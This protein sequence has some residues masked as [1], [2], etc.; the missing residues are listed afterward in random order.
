MTERHLQ[1]EA[2][3]RCPQC[4]GTPYRL[5]RRSTEANPEIFTHLVWPT[6]PGVSP[7]ASATLRCPADGCELA[8]GAA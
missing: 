3:F 8:R 1:L 5:Y 6:E 4:G 2:I 7:P